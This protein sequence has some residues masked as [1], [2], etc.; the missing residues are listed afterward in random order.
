VNRKPTVPHR[1]SADNDVPPDGEARR[2][3][4]PADTRLVSPAPGA[5]APPP[6]A[7]DPDPFNPASLRLV[8]DL[9]AGIGVKKAILKIPV[10]KPSKGAFCRANPSEDYRI[11]T[12]VID[13][14]DDI[15]ETFLV[16]GELRPALAAEPNLKPVLLTTAIDRQGVLFL[17]PAGLPKGD[18]DCD[19]WSSMREAIDLATRRWV[20]VTWNAGLRDYDV[21]YAT[22]DLGEPVWP[23]LTFPQI[24]RV[25]FK[26]RFIDTF[27]HPV[28]RRLRGEV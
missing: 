12:A 16:A 3:A 24:L 1:A 14:E 4:D 25:A 13:P 9:G 10:R 23:D 17:W 6:Q 7:A 5:P 15:G 21:A 26:D 20:R 11:A 19:A 18:R 28:L 2:P 22:A 27:D 8:P